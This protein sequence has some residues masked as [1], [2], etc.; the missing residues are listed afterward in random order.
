M[1]IC[2][3]AFRIVITLFNH[4]LIFLNVSVYLSI[5]LFI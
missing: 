3:D 4:L 5:D 2:P 1:H